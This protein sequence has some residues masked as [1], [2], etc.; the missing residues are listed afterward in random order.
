VRLKALNASFQMVY[1]ARAGP[2]G[3]GRYVSARS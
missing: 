2:G 1:E 3:L